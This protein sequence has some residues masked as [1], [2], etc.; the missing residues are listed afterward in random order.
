MAAK[1]MA[2]L[3]MRRMGMGLLLLL[4]LL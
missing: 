3:T 1:T 2:R 4:L